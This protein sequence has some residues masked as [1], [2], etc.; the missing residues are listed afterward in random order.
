MKVDHGVLRDAVEGQSACRPVQVNPDSVGEGSGRAGPEPLVV[1][2]R[3]VASLRTL[4]TPGPLVVSQQAARCVSISGDA[5]V[6]DADVSTAAPHHLP[7][8]RVQ[9]SLP[10]QELRTALKAVRVVRGSVVR[11]HTSRLPVALS[12]M[13]L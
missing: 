8:R 3:C 5:V 1:V 4:Q 13:E 6:G 11:P 12:Q 7:V 10:A 2:T 9:Q